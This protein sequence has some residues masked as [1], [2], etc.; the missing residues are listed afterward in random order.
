MNTMM[1]MV[2]INTGLNDDVGASALVFPGKIDLEVLEALSCREG[3]TLAQDINVH[4]V[5]I[6]NDCRNVVLVTS[7]EDGTMGSYAH[8]V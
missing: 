5:L 3:C 1:I 4:K 7:I 8:I 6:A 2:E